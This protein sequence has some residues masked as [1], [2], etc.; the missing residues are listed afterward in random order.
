MTLLDIAVFATADANFATTLDAYVNGANHHLANFDIRLNLHP[1]RPSD[2]IML[3]AFG[4]VADRP[5][6]FGLAILP[7]DVRAAAHFALPQG[8]GIPVIFCLFQ[9]SDAGL[10]VYTDDTGANRGIRWL[11]YIL[12]NAERLNAARAVMLHELI[13]AANY[14][15]DAAPHDRLHDTSPSSVMRANEVPNVPVL[16]RESHSAVLRNAYFAR[17]V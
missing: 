15:G 8:R 9:R 13:H 16:M 6:D 1:A 4:A 17:H 10:T 12:I 7:G 5:P 2:P 11:N 3:P 14:V